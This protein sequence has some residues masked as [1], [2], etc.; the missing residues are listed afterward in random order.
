MQ[1][2]DL[3]G[4]C[5]PAGDLD[6]L[7]KG[8]VRELLRDGVR[9]YLCRVVTF[10]VSRF[11]LCSELGWCPPPD[12]ARVLLLVGPALELIDEKVTLRP[13]HP[14][15]DLPVRRRPAPVIRA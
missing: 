5:P 13:L 8:P 11:T 7:D 12:R 4:G 9:L 2:Q 6:I 15:L 1:A 10:Q 3:V 14:L